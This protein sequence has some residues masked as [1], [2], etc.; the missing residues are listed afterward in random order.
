[1]QTYV[2]T[3]YACLQCAITVNLSLSMNGNPICPSCRRP[4]V[5]TQ[6]E[7][8]ST[9]R[10]QNA[11]AG[12]TIAGLIEAEAKGGELLVGVDIGVNARNVRIKSGTRV[13]VKGDGTK[14]VIGVKIG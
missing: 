12:V 5:A 11:Q 8:P 7:A 14:T 13:S 9:A 4:L 3:G 1:M 10:S 6:H 2:S